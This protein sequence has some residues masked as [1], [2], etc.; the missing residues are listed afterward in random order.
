MHKALKSL[1]VVRK[2]RE[3]ELQSEAS[4]LGDVKLR[5]SKLL[6]E[7]QRLLESLK[8]GR[9]TITVE[10]VP[11]L[12]SYIETVHNHVERIDQV[13]EELKAEAERQETVVRAKFS[14]KKSFDIV[15]EQKMAEQKQ[16]QEARDSA[17]RD[18]LTTMRWR[19]R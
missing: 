8:E 5:I 6:S 2:I 9:E 12:R 14:D 4:Y 18:D 3:N 10:T 16:D 15:L 7:R 1:S 13:L 19:R 11:Y 17:E